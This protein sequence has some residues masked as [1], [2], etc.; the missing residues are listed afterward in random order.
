MLVCF[1]TR[2]SIKVLLILMSDWDM[3]RP[4][5]VLPIHM[6]VWDMIRVPVKVLPTVLIELD[7]Y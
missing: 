2:R 7:N 6:S 1:V 3:I 4:V 5:K